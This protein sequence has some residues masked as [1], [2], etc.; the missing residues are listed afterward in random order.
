MPVPAPARLDAIEARLFE[1]VPR[2]TPAPSGRGR[3]EILPAALLWTGVLVCLLRGQPRAQAVWR[4]LAEQGLWHFPR[5]AVSA[6]AVRVRLRRAGPGVLQQ[7]FAELTAELTPHIVGDETLAPFA[8]GVY[9]LDES[10]LDGVARTLPALRE[11]PAGDDR[12]LPGKLS[13]VFDVRRQLFTTVQATDLPRQ[14]ERVAARDLLAAV[15]PKSL[16]LADLGYFGYPW[17]DELTA[18]GYFYVSKARART[19]V[20]VLHVLVDQPGLREEVVWLGAYRSDKARYAV[21]RITVTVGPRTWTYLTN[22]VDPAMLSAAEV[23]A[24]YGRRWDIELAFKLLKRELHLHLLWSASWEQVLTQVWGALI[25]AQAALSLRGQIAERA[26]IAVEQVSLPLVLRDT[27]MMVRDGKDVVSWI[28]SMPVVKG[29]YLRPARRVARPVPVPIVVHPP[30]PTLPRER[31]PRYAGRRCGP[32]GI[33]RRP[34]T[35]PYQ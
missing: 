1:L 14:N 29:G 13:A 15:P 19:S 16:I 12:L 17:F 7:L 33:D 3:P 31:E 35:S 23:V 21:R 18:A 2:L 20:E 30:P 25:I 26:D 34:G 5:V 28:A 22:V 27:P 4:L 9:V 24:L 8:A 11:V 6:E 32:G 10:T